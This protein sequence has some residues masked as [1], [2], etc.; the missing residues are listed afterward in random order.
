[1]A[2]K[3]LFLKNHIVI[4][5]ANMIFPVCLW[6]ITRTLTKYLELQSHYVCLNRKY[7][8]KKLLQQTYLTISQLI[9]CISIIVNVNSEFY[10]HFIFYTANMSQSLISASN[11]FAKY[12]PMGCNRFSNNIETIYPISSL[13]LDNEIDLMTD[14]SKE[15]LQM[16]PLSSDNEE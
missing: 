8:I 10:C 16:L 11:E 15:I 13:L 4:K 14:F 7:Q 6:S 9:V 1:M 12:L 5:R 2:Q 3:L